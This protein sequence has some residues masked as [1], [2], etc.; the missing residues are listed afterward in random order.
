[1]TPQTFTP[2]GPG[3]DVVVQVGYPRLYIFP[4]IGRLT[5]ATG[6]GH[7]ITG[8]VD[9]GDKIAESNESDNKRVTVIRK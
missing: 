3:D 1:M 7:T 8:T 9:P 5:S 2:G 4:F 6:G